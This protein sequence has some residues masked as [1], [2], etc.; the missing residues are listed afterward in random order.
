MH[1]VWFTQLEWLYLSQRC[2]LQSFEIRSLIP[3]CNIL[4]DVAFKNLGRMD[5]LFSLCILHPKQMNRMCSRPYAPY[6]TVPP[7][8]VSTFCCGVLTYVL[9]RSFFLSC[10]TVISED[11][12]VSKPRH[13]RDKSWYSPRFSFERAEHGNVKHSDVR[14][15]SNSTSQFVQNESSKCWLM[16]Y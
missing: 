2:S 16:L 5:F 1:I 9:I 11:V 4:L 6:G 14:C 10:S 7:A 8:W 13:W 15:N 3:F 12:C